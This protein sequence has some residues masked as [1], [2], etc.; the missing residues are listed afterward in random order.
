MK[1]TKRER[2]VLRLVAY[3]YSSKEIAQRL[4]L[5]DETIN[6]HRKNIMIN[7]G[8]KNAARMVRV[9]FEKQFLNP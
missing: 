8:V 1:I 6:S 9:A 4:F 7:L 3:E 2:E 5:S